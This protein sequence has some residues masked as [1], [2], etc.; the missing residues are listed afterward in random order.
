LAGVPRQIPL[1]FTQR[2]KP[3]L[4]HYRL[5]PD[6]R[7]AGHAWENFKPPSRPSRPG[8]GWGDFDIQ[9]TLSTQIPV[10][11]LSSPGTTA[12]TNMNFGDP[13][14]W[15]TTFQYHLFDYL[16][17][18]LEVNY[19]YRPNGEHVGL[20][21]VMLTPDF[22]LG[23]FQI[24]KDSPTWPINLIVGAGYQVAVTPNPV[25]QNNFVGTIQVTF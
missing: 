23:R 2:T 13:I 10:S 4:Y 12:S 1:H 25:T 11:A 14:L 6:V 19:E 5:L 3:Q 20:T 21:Q 24:G 17:P 15:N 22:I 9:M 8:K 18:E 16:C 7:P